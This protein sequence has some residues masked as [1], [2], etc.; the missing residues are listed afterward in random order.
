VQV[1]QDLS[2]AGTL[3][4]NNQNLT[5]LRHLTGTGTLQGLAGG[6]QELITVGGNFTVSTYTPNGS[7]LLLN[8]ATQPVSVSANSF[9]DL[10]IAKTNPTDV[11]TSTGAW[12]VTGS[13]LLSTGTWNAGS[14][15]HDI[16]VPWDATSANFTFTPSTS[17]INMTTNPGLTVNNSATNWFWNLTISTSVSLSSAIV[18]LNDLNITATGALDVSAANRKITVGHNWTRT[19]PGSFNYRNGE[20]EFDDNAFTANGTLSTTDAAGETFWNLSVDESGGTMTYSSNLT[21]I[22]QISLVSGTLEEAGTRTI[23]MGTAVSPA[24]VIWSNTA[25]TVGQAGFSNTTGKV[26]FAQPGSVT[27]YNILGRTTFYDFECLTP[28]AVLEFED[29]TTG[30]YGPADRAT[31][32]A[33]DFHVVGAAGQL[34]TLDNTSGT[35]AAA[36]CGPNPDIHHWVLHITGTATIDYID[37]SN[38]WAPP[39]AT[40]TPGPHYNKG[41]SNCNWLFYIPIIDSW[42]VDSDN[43]GRIDRIR[44]QVDVGTQLNVRP[45]SPPGVDFNQLRFH[46]EGYTV[47]GIGDAGA[48]DQDVFDILLQEGTH[49]DTDA[50]PRWQLLENNY[51]NG[52]LGKIGGAYVESGTQVHTADDGA[53]PVITYTLAVVG[54]N[55]V[56]AHFSEPVFGDA[57]G[58][59]SIATGAILDAANPVTLL[60]PLEGSGPSA[61]AAM[62]QLTNAVT[63]GD[64]IPYATA[65]T[66][67][68]AASSVYD[69]P[70]TVDPGLYPNT[71]VDLNLRPGSKPMLT[72]PHRITDVG[73]GLV[74]PV[75]AL[76]TGPVTQQDP[77]RGGVGRIT[78]FDGSGWLQDRDT[79]LQ[80]SI[81]APPPADTYGLDLAYDVNPA[82]PILLS[83]LWI[84]D[85][86]TA[87]TTT[88]FAHG[89][90][91]RFHNGDTA[92]RQLT[93]TP[94]PGALREFL[95][96]GDDPEIKDGVD[97]QFLFVLDDGVD[98]FPCARVADPLDPSSAR[99]WAYKVR[100]LRTQHGEAT[101]TNNVINPLR[102][103]QA[104]VYYRITQAGMVTITVFDLKGD[105]VEVLYR[106]HRDPGEYST[107]WDG[108]N[109]GGRVVTR[110][111]YFVK[112]VGPDIDEIRKVLVVK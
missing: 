5:V 77:L 81:L 65:Q 63:A 34:I 19:A 106:G 75:F 42:T 59:T 101:V 91:D 1:S 78:A 58:T 88:L 109:R 39:G 110:G 8:G 70:Y 97:L 50:K 87:P 13:L 67:A 92:A 20:V 51:P 100:D 31:L 56:Y 85:L 108:R 44:V 103:E 66:L 28:G 27:T 82:D 4:T 112:I 84:P 7:K 80:A 107:T 6:L 21:I 30:S 29:N 72:T 36:V 105:I 25:Y 55:K 23:T 3:N 73:L 35:D 43:D 38:S 37:V 12:T 33:G 62:L 96:P 49:E 54:Q 61:H 24:T 95:I 17:T 94:V 64:V 14:Y 11:V 79:Q 111:V 18:V 41:P 48:N 89:G 74:E 57:G 45:P 102:G 104:S 83:N 86:A 90:D 76:T 69:Q 32:V 22:S 46:V 2:I 53:R 60:T 98:R 15:V 40:V 68:A 16:R 71:N 10:E 9:Y 93:G 99:P 52:L 26:S 47:T